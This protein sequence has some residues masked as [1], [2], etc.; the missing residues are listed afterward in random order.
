MTLISPPRVS[1]L[2]ADRASLLDADYHPRCSAGPVPRSRLN[3]Q[4]TAGLGAYCL[5][6][7]RSEPEGA[8]RP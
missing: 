1:L 3:A 4:V 8:G 2:G 7:F 6:H 5:G